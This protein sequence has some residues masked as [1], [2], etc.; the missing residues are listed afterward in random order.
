MASHRKAEALFHT[1]TRLMDEDARG[2]EEAFRQALAIDPDIPELH[3]NLALLLE[4]RGN[5]EEGERHYRCAIALRPALTQAS[6]NLG[7]MLDRQHRFSEAEAVYRQALSLDPGSAPGW[8]NLG[9]LLAGQKREDEAEGCYR[10]A[11]ALDPGYGKAAFNLAYLLLRQ[12]R[13][14]EGWERLECRQ[15]YLPLERYLPCPRWQG[16]SLAGKSLLIGLESGHGDMIQFSR[17]AR[18]VKQAGASRV[19]I[20]CQPALKA[21][22]S[23]HRDLDTVIAID[24]PFAADD[25][26]FWVPPLSLPFLFDTR[27]DTIPASL[28][29]LEA[30][31]GRLAHWSHRIGER[32]GR[33]RV[34]LVWKGNPHFENDAERSLPSLS[35]LA[36]L[37]AIPGIHYF[38]LQKGEGEDEAAQPPLALTNLGPEIG[39]FADTAAIVAKLD[40]VISVDTAV[41]HLAG[42]LGRHCWLMLPHYK[43]DWRWLS[44]R[45]DSPWYPGVMELFWQHRSGHWEA[46]VTEM[47]T[48]LHVLAGTADTQRP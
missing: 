28:P 35:T 22:F 24:T 47:A 2:A 39:D 25:W 27:I 23:H 37:G 44:G 41:A 21:L 38:S 12:G 20:L 13:Y 48:R 29:Y 11:M 7:V 26:D 8:S 5:P 43:P 31:A 6:L 19:G 32:D 40:L 4:Q 9:V 46:T 42:A 18:L 36:P 15:W 45:R 1:G 10:K 34:G 14:A 17:Y 16:E 3:A 33:L 30:D